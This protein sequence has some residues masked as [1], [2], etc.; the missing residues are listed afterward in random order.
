MKVSKN[1]AIDCSFLKFLPWYGFQLLTLS[2]SGQ[3]SKKVDHSPRLSVYFVILNFLVIEF[4]IYNVN[5]AE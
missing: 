4:E 3:L 5:H 1:Y 2:I